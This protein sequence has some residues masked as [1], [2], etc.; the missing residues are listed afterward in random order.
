MHQTPSL[1]DADPEQRARKQFLAASPAPAPPAELPVGREVPRSGLISLNKPA[2]LASEIPNRSMEHSTNNKP[3]MKK[4]ALLS[5]IVLSALG[6]SVQAA[7]TTKIQ[8]DGTCA[9][10]DLKTATECQNAIIV[11][12]ADG[13]KETILCDAND[14]SKAFHGKICKGAEKVTAE[15][16][17]SVKDGKKTIALTKIEL[18]K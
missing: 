3:K 5:I 10:C 18:A 13:K 12:G 8:G 17:I 11:T 14:V 1:P 2:R 16:V 9:K 4:L 6:L 7:D 15:G